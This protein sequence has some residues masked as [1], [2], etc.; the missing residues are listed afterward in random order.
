MAEMEDLELVLRRF[1]IFCGYL[2]IH[3]CH[4]LGSV[5]HAHFLRYVGRAKLS[6]HVRHHLRSHL[7]RRILEGHQPLAYTLVYITIWVR[8]LARCGPVG[9]R[10]LSL[11]KRILY[12]D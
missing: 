4:V 1:L 11:R 10:G 9:L 5:L 8:S 7:H 12:M 2:L 6:S 3:S